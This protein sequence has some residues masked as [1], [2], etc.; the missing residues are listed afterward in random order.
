MEVELKS[1]TEEGNS[2]KI[3]FSGSTMDSGKINGKEFSWDVRKIDEKHYSI[4]KDK[5]SYVAE[6]LKADFKEKSFFLKVNGKKVK[7][8]VEDQYDELLK[9]LGMEDLAASKVDKMIAPM[10]GL[11]LKIKIEIGQQVE[12]DDPV[13]V[14]EA[15]KMENV[16]KSPTAG[17]IKSILV[18]QGNAVEKNQLLIEFE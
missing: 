5:R 17:V 15:M 12:K 3:A 14:L 6:V 1:I 7:I 10:P 18:K 11:V 9:K 13:L 16:L 8:K 4:V 2:Y